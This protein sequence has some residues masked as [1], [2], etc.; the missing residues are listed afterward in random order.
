M[1]GRT[2]IVG[3]GSTPY[4]KRG[5]SAPQTAI[6]LVGKA[7]IAAVE[8]AGLKIGDVDGFAYFAGGFDSGMLTETLGIPEFAFSPTL[9]GTGGGSLGCLGLAAGT[10]G[11]WVGEEGVSP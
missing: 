11:G 10:E 3:L 2:A 9:T 6:E 7:T 8:D 1:R 5:Q 4:Y